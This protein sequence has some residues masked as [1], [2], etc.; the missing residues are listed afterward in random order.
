MKV[1]PFS[2]HQAGSCVI[3]GV[4]Y[5]D[6]AENPADN[7]QICDASKSDTSWSENPGKS[8][9][10]YNSFL[11]SVGDGRFVHCDF[12]SVQMPEFPSGDDG[13]EF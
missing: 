9:K 3:A 6:K 1:S 10:L 2:F 11:C 4:C 13:L 5:V 7:C 12:Y 8:T